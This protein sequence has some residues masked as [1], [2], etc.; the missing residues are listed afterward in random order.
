MLSPSPMSGETIPPDKLQ[1]LRARVDSAATPAERVEATFALANEL[2]L[3]DPTTVRPILE[4]VV[5]EADAERAASCY[6]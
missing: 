6:C 5:A 4:Q 3:K 2:W 1:Q